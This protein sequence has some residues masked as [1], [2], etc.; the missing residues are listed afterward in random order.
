MQSKFRGACCILCD[1]D[2]K[3]P[4]G[5]F[6]E[7]V[8]PAGISLG[9]ITQYTRQRLSYRVRLDILIPMEPGQ[10]PW[11]GLDPRLEAGYIRELMEEQICWLLKPSNLEDRRSPRGRS[12]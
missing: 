7:I 12:V 4:L 6:D 10:G 8:V 11:E 1:C 2:R 5:K 3:G 9:A